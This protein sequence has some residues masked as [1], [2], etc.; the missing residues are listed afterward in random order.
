MG[1][2]PNSS[3]PARGPLGTF[4]DNVTGDMWS[5]GKI[6]TAGEQ[7]AAGINASTDRTTAEIIMATTSVGADQSVGPNGVKA[8][9]IFVAIYSVASLI[10]YFLYVLDVPNTSTIFI[11]YLVFAT[12]AAFVAILIKEDSISLRAKL[13]MVGGLIVAQSAFVFYNLIS[14]AFTGWALTGL[15]LNVA[16]LA[17]GV[18]IIRGR[19]VARLG[20]VVLAVISVVLILFAVK[21][22]ATWAYVMLFR[23][24]L[25]LP[26]SVVFTFLLFG[27][28]LRS[29]F[30]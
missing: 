23:T 18:G 11:Q 22:S 16:R 26:F 5:G 29:S 6:H 9:T 19:A 30:R 14:A 3:T 2:D 8:L 28:D 15:V 25:S 12:I 20:F 1:N 10:P 13:T 4:S 21:F 17:I 24:P 27:S 7:I